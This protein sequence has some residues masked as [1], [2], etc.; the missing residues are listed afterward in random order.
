[1]RGKEYL[2]ALI[3]NQLHSLDLSGTELVWFSSFSLNA[4]NS[5]GKEGVIKLSEA[6]KSTTSLTK[7]N[8]DSNYVGDEGAKNLAEALKWNSSLTDLDLSCNAF[9][10]IS[11]SLNTGNNI[12]AEGGIKLAEAL[13]SNTSLTS[14]NLFSKTRCFIS[15]S[16][17]YR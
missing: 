3:D 1:M 15:F 6:L 4:D 17:N 2:Q 12:G 11:F 7:L 5:I 10:F 9:C 16:L 13:K 8:L 14:L